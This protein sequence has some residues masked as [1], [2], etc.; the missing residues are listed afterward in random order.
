MAVF[1][2]PARKLEWKVNP[3]TLYIFIVSSPVIPTAN[4]VPALLNFAVVAALAK[5][6]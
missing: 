4:N 2:W 1:P 6:S 3:G 5:V